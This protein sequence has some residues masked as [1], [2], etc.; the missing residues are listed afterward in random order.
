MTVIPTVA[1]PVTGTT[2]V[3]VLRDAVPLLAIAD[4]TKLQLFTAL[5]QT[6]RPFHGVGEWPDLEAHLTRQSRTLLAEQGEGQWQAAGGK[7]DDRNEP[8][9]TATSPAAATALHE[10]ARGPGGCLW[11]DASGIGWAVRLVPPTSEEEGGPLFGFAFTWAGKGWI[12][13]PFARRR[14]TQRVEQQLADALR[15]DAAEHRRQLGRLSRGLWLYERGETLLWWVHAAVLAQR[16][17]TVLLPD[18]LLALAVWGDDRVRWPSNWRQDL[19]TVLQSL[20]FLHLAEVRVT[21]Q[22]WRPRFDSMSSCLTHVSDLKARSRRQDEADRCLPGCL[23]E[24]SCVKH[25]HFLVSVGPGF[26]G[27]L[28]QYRKAESATGVRIYDFVREPKGAAAE[29]LRSARRSGQVVPV[30]M[31]SRLVPGRTTLSADQRRVLQALVREVTRAKRGRGRTDRALILEGGLVP[32]A[33]GSGRVPCPLLQTSVRYVTFGGNGRLRGRG[34][35]IVG[36]QGRGWL[37]RCGYRVPKGRDEQI[38]VAKQFLNDLADMATGLGL[39]ITGVDAKR[40]TWLSLP[41]VIAL[42]E[43]TG[44]PRL[45]RLHLRV[46]AEA[47]YLER[48]KDCFLGQETAAADPLTSG[49][50]PITPAADFWSRLKGAGLT[51]QMLADHLGVTQSFVSQLR[52]GKR[53]WP[54]DMGGRAEAWVAEAGRQGGP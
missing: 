20:C 19:L 6:H 51:Q 47:D 9:F 12:F 21:R 18:V 39:I 46:F 5:G 8:T 14:A 23:L 22:S 44:W 49:D 54:K 2:E 7:Y 24:A 11:T 31:P 29:A 17:S 3:Q 13:D 25:H 26:L 42:A 38:E 30:F 53:A 15:A 36:K 37:W 32:A 50:I 48:W 35:R 52:S 33:G 27:V 16:R 10:L 1:G 28:E 45:E 43:P 40:G 34:Y 4:H 41:E